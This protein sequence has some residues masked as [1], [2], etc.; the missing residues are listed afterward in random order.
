MFTITQKKNEYKNVPISVSFLHEKQHA[1]LIK[2]RMARR[3][4]S[5]SHKHKS[6]HDTVT[7]VTNQPIASTQRFHWEEDV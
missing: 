4:S 5:E 2:I 6:I 3:S 7:K 1:N